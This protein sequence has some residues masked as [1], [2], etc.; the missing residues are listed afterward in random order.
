MLLLF[1]IIIG[2]CMKVKNYIFLIF[3]MF[4]FSA[5]SI[6]VPTT[7]GK[8]QYVY[9]M[10]GLNFARERQIYL[11]HNMW[12]ED[13][14]A[15]DSLNI[16]KGKII[17]VGSKVKFVESYSGYVLFKTMKDG[18]EYRINNDSVQTLLSD[19]VQFHRI[20]G[21]KNPLKSIVD[22]KKAVRLLQKGKVI[23]GM[24]REEVVMGY[25]LPPRAFTPPQSKITWIYFLDNQLKTRHVVFNKENKV[26]YIFDC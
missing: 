10:Y 24:S 4:L 26:I 12:Y 3:I 22:N 1:P 15:I 6:F 18:K 13:P 9:D 11:K 8:L 14:M 5:C 25:G 17:P 21:Y 20:F 16:I 19:E 23:E 2:V 7:E